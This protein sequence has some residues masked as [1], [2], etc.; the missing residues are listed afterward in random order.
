MPELSHHI[1]VARNGELHG[2]GF[3]GMSVKVGEMRTNL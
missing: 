1:D 2:I 3:I